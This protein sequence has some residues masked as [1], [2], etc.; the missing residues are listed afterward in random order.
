MTAPKDD[1]HTIGIP[2]TLVIDKIGLYGSKSI[3]N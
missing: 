2:N 3:K 1:K